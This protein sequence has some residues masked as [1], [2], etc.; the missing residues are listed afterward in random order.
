[1][2]SFAWMLSVILATLSLLTVPVQAQG[3]KPPRPARGLIVI[4]DG[5]KTKAYA[6]AYEYAELMLDGSGFKVT[7]TN[8]A[9]VS[10]PAGHVV[11]KVDYGR[12]DIDQMLAEAEKISA[13]YKKAEPILK[14]RIPQLRELAKK[15]AELAK[16]AP[17]PAP[18]PAIAPVVPAPAPGQKPAPLPP[19]D[20]APAPAAAVVKADPAARYET[21]GLAPAARISALADLAMNPSPEHLPLLMTASSDP[22]R[23][24]RRWAFRG[25]GKLKS[26]EAFAALAEAL[27]MPG[28]DPGDYLDIIKQYGKL[29][30]SP[31]ED[32]SMLGLKALTDIMASAE[33][34]D[35]MRNRAQEDITVCCTNGGAWVRPYLEPLDLAGLDEIKKY[36]AAADA[37]K[38]KLE[39]ERLAFNDQD[40]RVLVTFAIGGKAKFG[41]DGLIMEDA[42]KGR[43]PELVA[44]IETETRAMSKATRTWA[45]THKRKI[46]ILQKELNTLRSGDPRTMGF[47]QM[48]ILADL[49]V[50]V[51]KLRK[52]TR[53]VA[54]MGA[55]LA[56]SEPGRN[57]Y[58]VGYTRYEEADYSANIFGAFLG[59]AAMAYE[60]AK[61]R[62]AIQ[63]AERIEAMFKQLS[64]TAQ[65][66]LAT[67]YQWSKEA[68]LR[69]E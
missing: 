67:R 58:Y 52:G 38:A 23:E 21:P 36:W 12:Q 60:E 64:P 55:S 7:G 61:T 69:E 16:N 33:A 39:E 49:D 41:A 24:I 34:S 27:K 8:G 5:T 22:D 11:A 29:A 35:A 19:G 2:R 66:I 26:P 1:M 68:Y 14:V 37:A 15:K 28:R 4:F 45:P 17:Q 3:K 44:E 62:P 43:I 20:P 51:G 63:H 65:T 32:L 50:A 31:K 6:E 57:E 40:R 53:V 46:E 18:A 13:F 54:N 10:G 59:L 56:F 30:L 48:D 42:V 25:I 9:T 47:Y